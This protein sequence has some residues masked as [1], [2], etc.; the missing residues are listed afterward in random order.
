M[1]TQKS[2]DSLHFSIQVT[3]LILIALMFL[4]FTYG[5][6]S[7]ENVASRTGDATAFTNV[8][9]IP[10]NS[11]EETLLE[12]Q[13]VI[14]SDGMVER[15]GDADAI[16]LPGDVSVIDG[17]GRYL[18]P[19]L[20][21]MH[22]HVPGPDDPQYLEDVLFLY[23]SNGVTTVR[24][25]SGHPIHIELRERLNRGEVVGP[26]FFTASPWLG[27]D[28][29]ADTETVDRVVREYSEAGYDLLKIGSM[30]REV[31][32]QMA[33]TAHEVG[34]PFAGHIPVSVGLTRALEV[35]Q[36]S[37]DHYD[38]YV[39][40]MAEEHP[41][42]SQRDPGFFGSGVVD[43][44]DESR[45]SE[46]IEMTIEAGAWNVPTLSI[47]EH[48]AIPDDPEEMA[49]WDEMKYLPQDLVQG[50]VDSK[51]TFL[52]RYNTDRETAMRLVDLR[53]QITRELH[54]SGAPIVL[55]SDAPQFFNVPGF[56]IHREMRM[57]VDSGL[58]P[59]E[60][61]VTGTRNAGRYYEDAVP[62]GTVE[63]GSLANLILLEA[64]PIED[65][66]HVRERTGVMIRGEWWP[67]E[68]IQERLSQIAE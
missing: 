6:E 32:D 45:L 9:V 58:T 11:D 61:L 39:E 53:R 54:D 7:T 35:E 60:V 30:E 66:G 3:A 64:N 15:I 8:T 23:V 25:M 22:G 13:T 49:A 55:G 52:D 65:I 38:R 1:R 16:D 28:R 5:C 2:T 24:N 19:G 29:V 50:W 12:N 57:M 56:S 67:E 21:E 40:F 10:M 14:V 62:F 18:M 27:G 68:R 36:E 47:V 51:R 63:E 42:Y 41:E 4:L 46:A 20:S 43:L 31:Y 33:E 26:L 37:I 34:I 48:L 44:V 17:T 59:Y